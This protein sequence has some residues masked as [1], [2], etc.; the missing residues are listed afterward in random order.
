MRRST[1]KKGF[2]LRDHF[3][4]IENP[5]EVMYGSNENWEE[6]ICLSAEGKGALRSTKNEFDD[7]QSAFCT[8][9]HNSFP[10]LAAPAI[11]SYFKYFA[12]APINHCKATHVNFAFGQ[13][14]GAKFGA[15]VSNLRVTNSVYIERC[16]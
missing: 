13:C 8:L 15:A 3:I 4:P 2:C 1:H 9:R 5:Y 12:R 10:R 16:K 7:E 6:R 14:R 11:A